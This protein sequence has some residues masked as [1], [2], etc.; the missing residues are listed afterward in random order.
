VPAFSATFFQS[1][2]EEAAGEGKK[3]DDIG[4]DRG[5]AIESS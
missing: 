1:P 5:A 4:M 3:K 2:E